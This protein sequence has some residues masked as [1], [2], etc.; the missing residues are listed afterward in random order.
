MLAG[1][2]YVNMGA[3]NIFREPAEHVS[4]VLNI[5]LYT[6]G[7][8][9]GTEHGVYIAFGVH[10]YIS[11]YKEIQQRD[12]SIRFIILQSEQLS[13]KYFQ[14][15]DYIDILDRNIVHSWSPLVA[16]E[17]SKRGVTN[18]GLFEFYFPPP[19]P[20]LLT[21][22]RTTDI[23]F[24]GSQTPY[25]MKMFKTITE[26]FPK[27]VCKFKVTWDLTDCEKMTRELVKS[28]CVINV[29]CFANSSLETHRVNKALSC[30]CTVISFYSADEEM[31]E[32]YR[33][34]IHFTN[35]ITDTIEEWLNGSLPPKEPHIPPKIS[36]HNY[37][38]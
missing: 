3:H 34:H 10:D 4:N 15:S 25:R 37:L 1:V 20:H 36:H 31:N 14:M 24:C 27:I 17:L 8:F 5:P 29:P 22:R 33:H 26:R 35:N 9:K 19:P 16:A 12:P 23:F 30:G 11:S 18:T 6:P 13:S 28:K 2:I 7:K 21:Q 32:Q 38:F